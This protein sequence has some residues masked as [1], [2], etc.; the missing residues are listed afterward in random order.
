MN[1]ELGLN[2]LNYLTGIDFRMKK[3]VFEAKL[4][5]SFIFINFLNHI[6]P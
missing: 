5:Y 4:L 2:Q 6:F 1:G 3:L